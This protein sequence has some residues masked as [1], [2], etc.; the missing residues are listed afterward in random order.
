MKEI[1]TKALSI[2][3]S[4]IAA[5]SLLMIGGQAHAQSACP[6]DDP[7]SV[8]QAPG[9]SCTLGD[10]T[11]SNFTISGAPS[12]AVVGFGILNNELFAVTLSRDGAFFSAGT[13]V[14][15]YT[16]TAT[17]P[18]TIVMGTVG[19]DVS[20]PTV[21]TIT[22]MNGMALTP[23]SINNGGT[24]MIVFS[25]GVGSVLVDNT[26][27]II[28]ATAE[29]NS[30]SNDFS[31]VMIGVPEPASLSLFGLGLLGLGFVRRRPS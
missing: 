15:N 9:F 4:G 24:G 11:F 29:L 16:V 23:P 14:F 26:S 1:K 5:V 2:G 27:H 20:F 25:P 6:A 30:I 13:V 8:V 19:V 10:K 12:G 28:G 21:V 3:L 22:T 18:Q 17:A 31:Q 7:I